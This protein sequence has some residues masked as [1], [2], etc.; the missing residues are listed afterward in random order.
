MSKSLNLSQFWLLLMGTLFLVTG[1]S[2]DGRTILGKDIQVDEIAVDNAT[3]MGSLGQ[4]V[5][6]NQASAAGLLRLS[7]VGPALADR[8]VADRLRRG[9]FPTVESLVR[10]KGI[11]PKTLEKLRPFIVVSSAP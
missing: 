1:W 6:L 3:P 5:D 2:F 11:G 9:P 10:V 7:G 4:K 8:I